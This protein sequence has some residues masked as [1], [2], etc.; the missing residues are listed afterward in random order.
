MTKLEVDH[1]NDCIIV[2]LERLFYQNQKQVLGNSQNIKE[3]SH[4]NLLSIN[5]I[6]F[7][8]GTIVKKHLIERKPEGS[9]DEMDDGAEDLLK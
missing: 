2:H 5:Q 9:D 4:V 6:N 7:T 8:K 1:D 3:H